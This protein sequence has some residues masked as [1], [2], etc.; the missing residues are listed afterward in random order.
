MNQEQRNTIE[1]VANDLTHMEE[2]LADANE[3]QQ[4]ET[5]NVL[6]GKLE[7]VISEHKDT[8][9]T[10]L[11][12]CDLKIESCELGNTVRDT[13]NKLKKIHT[14]LADSYAKSDNPTEELRQRDYVRVL[15]MIYENFDSSAFAITG[16]F[17]AQQFKND[18]NI[19][20][21]ENRKN[22]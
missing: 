21:K 15:V 13:L 8:E 14:E 19:A 17:K 5:L 6:K 3:I 22:K 4:A 16:G 18:E 7:E 10:L 20:W 9:A 2:Y 1:A 11:T 12:R